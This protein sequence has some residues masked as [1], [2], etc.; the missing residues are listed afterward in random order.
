MRHSLGRSVAALVALTTLHVQ[1]SYAQTSAYAW[2]PRDTDAQD[3]IR[4]ST[5]ASPGHRFD[6]VRASVVLAAPASQLLSV[7]QAFEH[8]TLWYYHAAKVRVLRRPERLPA[9]TVGTDGQLGNVPD[10]GPWL[11]HFQQSVPA[12]ADRWALLRCAIRAGKAG[13]ILVE[14]RSVE[15]AYD[16]PDAVRMK[17]HGYWQLKPLTATHTEVTFMIDVDPNTL[18]PAF[19]VDP[20]LRDVVVQTLRGLQKRT[21][22]TAGSLASAAMSVRDISDPECCASPPP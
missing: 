22:S 21:H 19:L 14:F 11:L 5:S 20:E 15:P 8:Y 9:V 13:S 1:P 17:M 12:I 16:V 3:K 10:V 2:R 18:A 6:A 7:L 4:L